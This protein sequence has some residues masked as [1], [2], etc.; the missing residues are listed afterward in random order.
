MTITKTNIAMIGIIMVLT[1]ALLTV[2]I[3]PKDIVKTRGPNPDGSWGRYEEPMVKVT[4]VMID[5]R[6]RELTLLLT[7]SIGTGESYTTR[8]TLPFDP[9]IGDKLNG[10][11]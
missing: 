7:I 6:T 1:I 4:A 3:N 8:A 9:T 10:D 11:N 2:I 5:H